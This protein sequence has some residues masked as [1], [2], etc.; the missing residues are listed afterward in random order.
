MRKILITLICAVLLSSCGSSMVVDG[1][2][3]ETRGLLTYEERPKEIRYEPIIGNVIWGVILIET[4][5]APIYFFGF[6][7]YEPVGKVDK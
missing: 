7:M 6:S 4:V 5:I 1:T 3:Y 2:E